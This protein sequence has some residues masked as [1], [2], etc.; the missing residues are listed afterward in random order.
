MKIL[1]YGKASAHYALTARLKLNQI[2]DVNWIGQGGTQSWRLRSPNLMPLDFFVWEY[3][4]QNIF[5]TQPTS[6]DD[7]RQRITHVIQ[8]IPPATL[9]RVTEECQA[10]VKHCL[11]VNVVHFE[12]LWQLTYCK[13]KF[14]EF[15]THKLHN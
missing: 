3:V 7:L 13:H 10:G 4:M 11:Q 15:T 5:Q 9:L 2:F 8:N 1:Y 12:H 6:I 14:N